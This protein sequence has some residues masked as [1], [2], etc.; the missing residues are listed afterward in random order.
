[1]HWNRQTE[2]ER[3]RLLQLL[4][5]MPLLQLLLL[6]QPP[7]AARPLNCG[8]DATIT[9]TSQ[10]THSPF[11]R[12]SAR[13]SETWGFC[14]LQYKLRYLHRHCTQQASK[15]RTSQQTTIK[16]ALREKNL[17]FATD[18]GKALKPTFARNPLRF[19]AVNDKTNFSL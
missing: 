6:P 14:L 12:Y 19:A 2:R 18:N 7:N 5:R 9:G 10:Q 16:P 4:P 11:L 15:K 8:K 1:M 17:C 3:V 13:T